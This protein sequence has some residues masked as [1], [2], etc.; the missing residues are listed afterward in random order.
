M[1][2]KRLEEVGDLPFLWFV[3]HS[4]LDGHLVLIRVVLCFNGSLIGSWLLC[5]QYFP[6]LV[7]F[8]VCLEL[9]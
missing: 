5:M 3:I 8:G 9:V 2:D 1:T 7:S 4:S 6:S